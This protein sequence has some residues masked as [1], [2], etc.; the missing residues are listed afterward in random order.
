[1][2]L[3]IYFFEYKTKRAMCNAWGRIDEFFATDGLKG[4]VITREEM[5]KHWRP[6]I[7][8]DYFDYWDGFDIK[9]NNIREFIKV[10]G[11]GRLY[12]EEAQVLRLI[13]QT[14]DF[15]VITGIGTS[16]LV[17]ELQ[18]AFFF[19]DKK[20]RL[21]VLRILKK[22]NTK[23][24]EKALVKCMGYSIHDIKNE[25][26]SYLIDGSKD[27]VTEC[28]LDLK[29]YTKARLALYE[30]YTQHLAENINIE[31]IKEA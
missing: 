14:G 26:I 22:F 4:R 28:K 1:M 27:L 20:Y 6:I 25:T 19:L 18:H 5:V 12:Q 24:I 30:A 17:H 21:K 29:P 2:K 23:A 16:T 10:Y 11:Q 8:Y 13:P 9:S 15:V 7:H 3:P 31:R